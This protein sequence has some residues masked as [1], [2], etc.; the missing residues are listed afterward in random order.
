MFKAERKDGKIK[1]IGLSDSNLTVNAGIEDWSTPNDSTPDNK[2]IVIIGKNGENIYLSEENL[3]QITTQAM[4][5]EI[6]D[7]T[8]PTKVIAAGSADVIAQANKEKINEIIDILNNLIDFS[9]E[10][11]DKM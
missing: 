11:R 10:Q 9:I 5:S 4:V 8:K 3:K 6:A 1:Q 2:G 7:I